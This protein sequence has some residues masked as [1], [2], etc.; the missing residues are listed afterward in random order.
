M[1]RRAAN[2]GARFP[3]PKGEVHGDFGLI[4]RGNILIT[5]PTILEEPIHCG[6]APSAS[7]TWKA[8]GGSSNA[9]IA[10]AIS[11]PITSE[12]TPPCLG[13]RVC[14]T[15]QTARRCLETGPSSATTISPGSS[16]PVG[17]RRKAITKASWRGESSGWPATAPQICTLKTPRHGRSSVVSTKTAPTGSAAKLKKRLVRS[18]TFRMVGS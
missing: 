12:L 2:D 9:R 17:N 14:T 13:S 4:F 6:S 8:G 5:L 16:S 7:V 18:F 1:G 10:P 11:E 15:V 3:E